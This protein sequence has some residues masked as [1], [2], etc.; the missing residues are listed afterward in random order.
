M[1]Q[2]IV[3]K[4]TGK[5]KKGINKI[6]YTF[7]DIE[8]IKKDLTEGILLSELLV[9]H[10]VSREVVQK[11]FD[12]HIHA[13]HRTAAPEKKVKSNFILGKKTLWDF[14]SEKEMLEEKPYT[15]DTLSQEEIDFYHKYK[16]E[17]LL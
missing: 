17:N 15:W 11:I 4:L 1:E 9:K 16:I 13:K 12:E 14:K 5:W 2:E 3:I 7:Q 6:N 10:K 8:N